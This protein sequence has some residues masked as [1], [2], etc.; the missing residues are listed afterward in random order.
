MTEPSS[1]L[2]TVLIC[3]LFISLTVSFFSNENKTPVTTEAHNIRSK[4][5]V[6]LSVYFALSNIL[7]FD[8]N[9]GF[10]TKEKCRRFY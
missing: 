9:L 1:V 8:T 2:N 3:S 10:K 6:Q 7:S 5:R 4:R